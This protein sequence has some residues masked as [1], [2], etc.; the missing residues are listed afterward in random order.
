MKNVIQVT[1]TCET[2]LKNAVYPFLKDFLTIFEEEYNFGLAKHESSYSLQF[3]MT[4]FSLYIGFLHKLKLNYV[5]FAEQWKNNYIFY[6][7]S[8]AWEHDWRLNNILF[9]VPDFTI[10]V[11]GSS[12]NFLFIGPI[13]TPLLSLSIYWHPQG[14]KGWQ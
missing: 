7:W 1:T 8:S 14:N 4:F 3:S 6:F 5:Q 13:P 12:C 2:I 10:S 9:S 11:S